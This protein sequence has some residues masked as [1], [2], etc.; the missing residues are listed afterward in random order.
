MVNGAVKKAQEKNVI[1]AEMRMLRMESQRL[2]EHGTTALDGLRKWNK[3]PMNWYG[4][5]LRKDVG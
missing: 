1:A 3:C 4:H 5:V 2:R